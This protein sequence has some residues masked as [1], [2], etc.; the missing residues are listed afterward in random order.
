MAGTKSADSIKQKSTVQSKIMLILVDTGSSHSFVSSHFVQ[1]TKLPTVPMEQQKVKLANGNWVTTTKQVKGIQWYI[2]GHTFTTD[3]IVLDLLPYDAI[4]GFDCLKT[5][6]PMQC[7][8]Q[9]K[10]LQFQH[11]GKLITLKGL[12]TPPLSLST[13]SAKQVFKSTQANDTWAY[14]FV[15]SPTSTSTSTTTPKQLPAEDIQDLLLQYA[16]LFQDPKRLSPRSYDHGVP[17]YLD[18]VPV[19]AGPYHYS[20]QHKIEIETNLSNC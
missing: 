16:D 12:Q 18:S 2:Q 11:Q 14:V 9:A 20:P 13:I 1:L 4:L 19:N 17:L 8:W 7:D 15:D 10:T 3:M 6:S 5:F